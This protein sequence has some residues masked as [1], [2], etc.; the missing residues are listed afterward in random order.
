MREKHNILEAKLCEL[1]QR[2]NKMCTK[3]RDAQNE[4]HEVLHRDLQELLEKYEIREE[5]LHRE[6]EE[7]RSPAIAAL[8]SAQLEYCRRTG[9]ILQEELAGYIHGECSD[10][11]LDRLE[12]MALFAEYAADFAAQA[13][14]FAL[15][16]TLSA[17]DLELEHEEK[18]KEEISL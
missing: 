1:E 4:D 10:A 16:A 14:D 11:S 8:S 2:Y 5:Q 18:N 12:G 17:I 3:I 6:I 13:M 7:C 15:L 9:H